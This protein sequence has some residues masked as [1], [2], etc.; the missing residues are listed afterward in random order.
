MAPTLRAADLT[1]ESYVKAHGKEP[2]SRPRVNGWMTRRY[3]ASAPGRH[4]QPISAQ[5]G[6]RMLIA[7]NGGPAS[8]DPWNGRL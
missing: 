6:D 5:T 3:A 7:K 8:H 1:Y 2:D 4:P